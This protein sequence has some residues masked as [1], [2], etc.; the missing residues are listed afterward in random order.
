M[1]I[2]GLVSQLPVIAKKLSWVG[3]SLIA[4]YNILFKI[5]DK[6]IGMQ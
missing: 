5:G 6:Y 3:F 2:A 4:S 1:K